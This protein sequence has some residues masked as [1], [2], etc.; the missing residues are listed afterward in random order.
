MKASLFSGVLVLLVASVAAKGVVVGEDELVA[1]MERV[2]LE[3]KEMWMGEMRREMDKRLSLAGQ[4]AENQATASTMETELLQQNREL[5]QVNQRHKQQ[6]A[7]QQQQ[8]ANLNQ[9]GGGNVD[10]TFMPSIFLCNLHL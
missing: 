1:F 2:V 6:L 4:G 10:P 3:Q 8:I 5:I 9:Q 7:Y